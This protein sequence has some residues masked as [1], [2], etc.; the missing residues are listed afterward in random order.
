MAISSHIGIGGRRGGSQL[1]RTRRIVI[2]GLTTSSNKGDHQH[3]GAEAAD[4]DHTD[5]P[6]IQVNEL[7]EWHAPNTR[8]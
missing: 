1:A 6:W 5:R 7:Y 3:A 8:R 4:S 2:V